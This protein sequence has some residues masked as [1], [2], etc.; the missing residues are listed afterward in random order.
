MRTLPYL[1]SLTLL[2]SAAWRPN[3]PLPRY[4]KAELTGRF[5]PRKHPRFVAIPARYANR[6]G[7]YLRKEVWQAYQEMLLAA[8]QAGHQL[9]IVSATRNWRYQ[10]GIWNRKWQSYGP[11]ENTRAQRIL[12]YSSMPGTSRHH[13]GTEVDL[14]ALN[15]AYFENGAGL[16][17]Y[18][19]LQ[20]HA[21]QFGFYQPYTPF[22]RFR[23][24]GYREEK[25]HWSYYPI[26]RQLERAYLHL[27]DYED[28]RGFRGSPYARSLRVI[29]NYVRSVEAPPKGQ[30]SL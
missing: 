9:K 20:Q 17:L 26:A 24:R 25:W 18:R 21:A 12:R 19:W 16:K 27:V 30:D 5:V 4:S 28:L 3:V 29:N 23:D 13:W 22:H 10:A 7:M 8:Q 2:L 1:L 6:G 15:N 14:N 11:P